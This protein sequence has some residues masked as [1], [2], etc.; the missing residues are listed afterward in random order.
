MEAQKVEH[1]SYLHPDADHVEGIDGVASRDH[2]QKGPYLGVDDLQH[3]VVDVDTAEHVRAEH[4]N[5]EA[6]GGEGE[7]DERETVEQGVGRTI[8]WPLR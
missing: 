3:T 8:I 2:F 7:E 1:A 4:G 6:A 5:G